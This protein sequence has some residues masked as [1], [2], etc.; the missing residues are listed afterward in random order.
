MKVFRAITAVSLAT[1]SVAASSQNERASDV[2]LRTDLGSLKDVKD[3]VK[4]ISELP[5]GQQNALISAIRL[6]PRI[7]GGA[8]MKFEDAPY[9]VALIKGYAGGRYQFC[10]GTLIGA[11]TVVTAAHCVDNP[12]VNKDPTRLDFI[13]GTAIYPEGGERL[14]SRAIYIHPKWNSTNNDYDVAVIKLASASTLGQP[15]QVDTTD[16][17]AGIRATVTGWGATSEGSRG[18]EEL[19]GV[20]IPTVDNTTCNSSPSYNG[21]I[22]LQMLCAGERAGGLDSCQGDSGGPLVVGR[23]PQARLIGVVSWGHGCA[24]QDKYGVYTRTASVAAWISSL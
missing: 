3:L 20:E 18:S 1:F 24:R 21:L 2:L 11:D 5:S 22:T 15:I 16:I 7:V 17:G 14:K 10:G 9:Q 6:D 12:I 23:G 8:P 4:Q 13:A 19:L